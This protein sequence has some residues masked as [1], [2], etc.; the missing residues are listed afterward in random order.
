MMLWPRMQISP[1]SPSGSGVARLVH[2]AHLDAPDRVADRARLPRPIEHRE[3]RD[4]RGLRETEALE[5]RHAELRLERVHHLDRHRRTAGQADLQARD[6]VVVGLLVVQ[7]GEV[8]GGHT[9]EERDAIALDDLEGLGRLEARQQR[10]R[11]AGG[12]GGVL[13]ARLAEGVEERERGER[14]Q[15][16]ALDRRQAAAPPGRS[17]RTGSCA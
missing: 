16:L 15:I 7:Q 10:E 5:D 2:D 17:S 6:V 14:A 12:D 11:T 8:H 9:G 4:G 3:A 13:D 1:R